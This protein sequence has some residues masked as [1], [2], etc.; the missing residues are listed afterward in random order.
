[1]KRLGWNY[2]L[3]DQLMSLRGD[4]ARST[5]DDRLIPALQR[6]TLAWKGR[7]LRL[8]EAAMGGILEHANAF[9]AVDHRSDSSAA[10][11]ALLLEGIPSHVDLPDGRR[12]NVRVPL[13]DWDHPHRNHWD[14]ADDLRRSGTSR[15]P[16]IRDLIGYV[17]GLPLVLI[18]CV[19]R[20]ARGQWG[21]VEAGI[22]HLL[23]LTRGY[24]GDRVPDHA[25]LLIS[26]ARGGGLYGG[27]ASPAHAWTRW[28]EPGTGLQDWRALRA[29]L[30]RDLNGP[31]DGPLATH[32]E[33]LIGLLEP[34]RLAGFLRGYCDAAGGQP[35]RI[36]RSAQFFA[37]QAAFRHLHRIVRSGAR[38]DGQ[39]FL[40]PG[41]GMRHAR[42]WLLRAVARDPTLAGL[43]ILVPLAGGPLPDIASARTVREVHQ[44]LRQHAPAPLQLA[45]KTLHGW[46]RN[47]DTELAAGAAL[48]MLV[49]AAFWDQRPGLLK[50]LRAS[51][52]DASWLTL[53][54][55]PLMPHDA[56]RPGPMLYE[57]SPAC[58]VADRVTVPVWYDAVPR[59]TL[60]GPHA[61]TAHIVTLIQQH[62]GRSLRLPRRNLFA[63]LRVATVECAQRYQEAF[64]REGRLR[65][66]LRGVGETGRRRG[67][68]TRCTKGAVD[69]VISLPSMPCSD[70]GRLGVLYLDSPVGPVERAR[71][72]GQL[73]RRAPDKPY[74][75]LVDFTESRQA[76]AF[77]HEASGY[78]A[79]LSDN[80]RNVDRR[81]ALLDVALPAA[82]DLAASRA[83]LAPYWVLNAYGDDRDLHHR[84]RQLFC[85]R[86]T[87][88]GLALQVDASACGAAEAARQAAD[89]LAFQRVCLL[90][91]A[92][93][94]DAREEETFTSEDLRVRQWAREVT[95]ELQE[96][97]APY[98]VM[99]LQNE[100]A[101]APL[102]QANRLYTEL[103]R[104]LEHPA[105]EPALQ[106]TARCALRRLLAHHPEPASRLTALHAFASR[107]PGLLGRASPHPVSRGCLLVT[108]IA[109]HR[110]REHRLAVLGRR[111]DEVVAAGRTLVPERMDL[112]HAHLRI[113]LHDLLEKEMGE[114]ATHLVLDALLAR[115]SH[116][117]A[118][119]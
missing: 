91:D 92:V 84:G 114:D 113:Q 54:T 79:P 82:A 85:S 56:C 12:V 94:H 10:V 1:M 45:L 116:W 109:G 77:P 19:E 27:F 87:R 71:L 44:H 69:L 112:F 48:V 50:Q 63:E 99:D 96:P 2:L 62:V 43:R 101:G 17:N 110:L 53:A 106:E 7:H 83:A 55:A 98:D 23:R 86:V 29:V 115:S 78:P 97:P 5:L 88:L 25:Q 13:I 22:L 81:W 70:E 30:P 3:P 102:A 80:R 8:S 40:A 119:D 32:A 111:I 103:L 24:S 33:L 20:G 38:N 42:I 16:G 9:H 26:I 37:C 35:C 28:R 65:S 46:S 58:A 47:A 6:F 4:P 107:I 100:S 39:V 108:G 31:A 36:A 76:S 60:H 61:R 49:D 117:E 15:D 68:A 95:R 51:L 118:S 89:H 67:P 18:A 75:L 57:Y 72:I 34:A 105:D 59:L 11:L 90:R 52:P 74:A 64:Q 73:N 93:C 66:V 41:T 14:V 21:P 104:R